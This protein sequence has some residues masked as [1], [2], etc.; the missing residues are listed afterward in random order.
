MYHDGEITL[1]ILGG[2]SSNYEVHTMYSPA[3]TGASKDVAIKHV[4]S[5][6][7]TCLELA[8]DWVDGVIASQ[9]SRV[10]EDVWGYPSP[11]QQNFNN[12]V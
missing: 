10:G 5:S 6:L 7:E 1:R 8:M 9:H 4:A 11:D 3:V 12:F 2:G